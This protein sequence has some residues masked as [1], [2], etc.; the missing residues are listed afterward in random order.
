MIDESM[1]C[2]VKDSCHVPD[3][4]IVCLLSQPVVHVHFTVR[5]PP[6]PTGLIMLVLRTVS[7]NCFGRNLR[8]ISAWS[9]VPAGPPDPILGKRCGCKKECAP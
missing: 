4:A 1:Q 8:T 7:K 9:A 6:P 2:T 3:T 5:L